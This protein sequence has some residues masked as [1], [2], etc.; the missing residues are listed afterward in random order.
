M[1]VPICFSGCEADHP[2]PPTP[3]SSGALSMEDDRGKRGSTADQGFSIE[4]TRITF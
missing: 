4:H 3:R 1:R 2:P